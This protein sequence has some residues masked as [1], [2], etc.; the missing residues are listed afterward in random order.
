MSKERAQVGKWNKEWTL[1]TALRNGLPMISGN[2]I[3]LSCEDR[4]EAGPQDLARRAK[5]GTVALI[6][7]AKD[8]AHNQP[9]LLREWLDDY[10]DGLS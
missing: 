9:A 6:S 1:S 7:S 2:G 3:A 10:P 4:L 5:R 8:Q